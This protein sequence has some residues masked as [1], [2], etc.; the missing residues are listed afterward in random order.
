M[1]H[2]QMYVQNEILSLVLY[3]FGDNKNIFKPSL[4]TLFPNVENLIFYTT[5][6]DGQEYSFLLSSFFSLFWG[7]ILFKHKSLKT[8]KIKATHKYKRGECVGRSWIYS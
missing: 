1:G 6:F 3:L 4:L 8:I 2:L 7:A 5:T